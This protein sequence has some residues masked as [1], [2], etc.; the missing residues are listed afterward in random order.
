MVIRPQLSRATAPY[1]IRHTTEMDAVVI[2]RS[3]GRTKSFG[4]VAAQQ[5]AVR[6]L[7]KNSASS[8]TLHIASNSPVQHVQRVIQAL[9]LNRVP[10]KRIWT[11]DWRG[12]ATATAAA[13]GCHDG[14][15][16]RASNRTSI[17]AY[18]T[19][20]H[21]W[22][23]WGSEF[24]KQHQEYS[25]LIDDSATTLAACKE[26]TSLRTIHLLSDGSFSSSLQQAL[27][28]AMGWLS[29]EY[30]FSDV[31]YLR[32]KN[33][34][35]QASINKE[36]WMQ[37]TAE[38]TDLV[39]DHHL[40]TLTIV[41]VGAGLL[42][43]LKLLVVTSDIEDGTYDH[44]LPS[45]LGS[46]QQ[47]C[48]SLKEVHY[49]AYEPNL[50]LESACIHDLQVSGF[51]LQSSQHDGKELVFVR[52]AV[53]T[54]DEATV[55]VYVR[56][57]DYKD[58]SLYVT[59]DRPTPQ[60][61]VGCCFADL[62]QPYDLVTSLLRF[63]LSNSSDGCAHSLIYFPIT[64]G[65]VTQFLPPQPFE[66]SP[67]YSSQLVPSDTKA[68]AL[69]SKALRETHG[70]DYLWRTM[71]YFF[72]TVAAQEIQA[73]GCN[74]VAWLNRARKR[75]ST[76]HVSNVD[77]LFR[78]PR[79][80][81]WSIAEAEQDRIDWSQDRSS[82]CHTFDEIL[83]TAPRQVASV[84]RDVVVGLQPNEIRIQ[85]E[86]SL[87]SSGTELG[88]VEACY[89]TCACDDQTRLTVSPADS[90]RCSLGATFATE[91]KKRKVEISSSSQIVVKP[92][93]RMASSASEAT[94]HIFDATNSLFSQEEKTL[95]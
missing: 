28:V 86:C 88:I 80:G 68:F 43:M 35:D 11:P 66:R 17:N 59:S 50:G 60:L 45:L 27:G 61:I 30:R 81:E 89:D 55:T 14:C 95:W 67:D 82:R 41:D 63:F 62:F 71:L 24:L 90:Y 23:F 32:A 38:L 6:S 57:W 72:G 18:P 40:T 37:M 1:R 13:G 8:C 84:Q 76:I 33:V 26:E 73:E 54:F 75:H 52:P 83:F 51:R 92:R 58:D 64:F 77:L 2:L 31:D 85:T 42:S 49:Y 4:A 36:L 46:I 53:E 56:F 21:P 93:E 91:D 22:E 34:V 16:D 10:W 44:R 29:P 25:T 47:K 39:V 70:H 74:A 12:T 15:S 79:L 20:L 69:Y 7:L 5:D 78:I 48:R 87:V 3:K 65:G 9:G 19:K 94:V